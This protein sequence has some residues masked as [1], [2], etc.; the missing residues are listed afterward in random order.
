M[1]A[2]GIDRIT[3]L[4]DTSQNL[5]SSFD[6]KYGQYRVV[7]KRKLRNTGKGREVQFI[8]GEPIPI[9]FNIW[10]GAQDEHGTKKAISSWFEMILK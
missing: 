8:T 3:T 9:A 10:D 2:E 5:Q 7:L 4:P 1:F 6:F